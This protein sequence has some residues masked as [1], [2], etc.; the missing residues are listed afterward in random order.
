MSN[1]SQMLQEYKNSK[2]AIYGLGTETERV[3]AEIGQEFEIAGLLDSY[4]E[5]GVLYGQRI[6]SIAEAVEC[7]VKLILVVARPGSCKAIEKR[8]GKTCIE[9]EIVLLDVRGKNLC[10]TRKVSYDLGG[11]DGVTR[12][13]L[14]QLI[15]EKDV[16]SIDLFDTL[17]MRQTLFPTDVIEMVDCR[18]KEQGI[19]I[20]D[21]CSKRLESE[22]YLAKFTAPTL[23]DIYNHMLKQCCV[24]DITPETLA[25]MEW[26]IDYEL[27]IP[28]REMCE[29]I[30]EVYRQGKE[31]Y[32]V[33]D[34]YY[35]REQLV[36]VFEKLQFSSYTDILA[37]CEYKTG[38]TQQ[39]FEK[40]MEKIGGKQCVHIGDDVVAD[41]ENAK[42]SGI[43]ACRIYSGIDLLETV[44]YL[45][46][47]SSTDKL[48]DKIKI[49]MFVSKIFNSPFQFESQER[50]LTVNNAYDI[51]YLFFAPM[52][53]DFVIWFEEQVRC[54]QL[55]NI[56]FC[57]RDGYLIKKLYD[58]LKGNESSVYFLTS[59]TAAIRAG[60][61]NEDDI[62]YV[63]EM[64]FSGTLKEQLKE[65]FGI[66]VNDERQ[67]LLD[68]SR[69]IL[70]RAV[71]SR[72]GYK[73][74]I[75]QLGMQDGDI[76]FFDFVAKGTSQMYLG[77][78]VKNH[79]KGL[80]FLQLEE[81]HMR[82]KGLD[83]VPFYKND[84]KDHSAIFD[85]YYILETML[86]APMPSVKE[87][88]DRGEA[89][90]ADETR[91]EEDIRC[92]QAS[93]RGII[94][95]FRTYLNIC[96]KGEVSINKQIDEIFL[97]LLHGVAIIDE[98]FIKLKVEDPFFNRV[99]DI[100]NLI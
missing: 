78:L 81:D 40:L 52:I 19:F 45:G 63:E 99:T 54:Y 58:E 100:T 67:G 65:R 77:H 91:S 3:L 94:D 74:Y 38:K 57:A 36:K 48:A 29:F 2:I 34:T 93:Q 8:I 80:Y 42:K 7:Q 37:S 85:N 9:N 47:W 39:L 18:L 20:D 10:D 24:T 95:Y 89:C 66:S 97:S 41:V 84:E 31:V 26:Q 22:K 16:V 4:R 25:E 64:K 35:S 73:K 69:E 6:I 13:D 79:L 53:S 12:N 17:A 55:K 61:E 1:L 76:A 23:V 50:K 43:A 90:F 46:L 96:P 62:R 32:V 33:S 49:G 75:D 5:D 83:I 98:A 59:R 30:S 88:D 15:A 14:R 60:I 27:L 82:G 72:N 11:V 87:F 28:R 92:F 68:Y 21:F 71:V 56:W 70:D 51:G 44:G 86:T